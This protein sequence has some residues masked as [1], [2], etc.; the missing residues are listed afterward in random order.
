MK[1]IIVTFFLFSAS[2]FS[3]AQKTYYGIK[4]AIENYHSTSPSCLVVQVES[5]TYSGYAY[6]LSDV[7][8][9]YYCKCVS[10]KELHGN[11]YI[12]KCYRDIKNN[13]KI[14]IHDGDFH[15]KNSCFKKV[16]IQ[17]NIMNDSKNGLE[18]FINKY[19]DSTGVI[20]PCNIDEYYSIVKVLF[21]SNI[22]VGIGCVWGGAYIQDDRFYQQ[23]CN[24]VISFVIP[25]EYKSNPIE[26]ENDKKR[27]ATPKD[28]KKQIHVRQNSDESIILVIDNIEYKLVKVNGGN[29]IMGFPLNILDTF[30]SYYHKDNF[31]EDF[32]EMK[33][34]GQWSK[35]AHDVSLSD[36][37]MGETEVTQALWKAVMGYNNSCIKSDKHPVEK[38]SWLEC[39]KFVRK[40]NKL[41]NLH[42]SLPTE[43][44][45]EY[46]ARG[47]N[48]SKGYYYSGSD[49]INDVAWYQKNSNQTSHDVKTKNANEIGLYDMSGNVGEWC[50]DVWN[51]YRYTLLPQADPLNKRGKRWLKVVRNNGYGSC[52]GYVWIYN[53]WLS[54]KREKYYNVGFRLA[55]NAS[56]DLSVLCRE[57]ASYGD[58]GK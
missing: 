1:K 57:Q 26:I 28:L 35:P 29:F 58:Y 24:G 50:E 3:F 7:F 6:V 46:A 39:Q 27:L 51:T 30:D 11:K 2:V 16:T 8:R 49:S 17:E 42:F 55:L 34:R 54:R 45:W 10:H 32:R 40:L 47:G 18:Y 31:L 33:K 43:A 37:Y 15:G 53:R 4:G 48:K 13:K 23:F 9:D 5:N 20:K 22:Q 21:D 44:Q 41:T 38:V 19:F 12:K 25:K 14:S 36:Y 52:D 56:S